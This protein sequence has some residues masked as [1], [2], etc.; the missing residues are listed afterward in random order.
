[1]TPRDNHEVIEVHLMMPEDVLQ[2]LDPDLE[3]GVIPESEQ[4]YTSMWP[5]LPNDQPAEILICRDQDAE[6]AVRERENVV[7]GHSRRVLAGDAGGIVS[8]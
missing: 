2:T 1:V 6:L 3:L 7:I 4:D 5:L 8:A